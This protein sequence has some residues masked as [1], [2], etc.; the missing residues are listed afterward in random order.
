MLTLLEP[1]KA[2]EPLCILVAIS[3]YPPLLLEEPIH[4]RSSIQ[5][6]LHFQ[7]IHKAYH[8]HIEGHQFGIGL[9]HL[10]DGLPVL[11][12]EG[13]IAELHTGS[14]HRSFTH[15]LCRLGILCERGAGIGKVANLLHKFIGH[16]SAV[17][18]LA[19]SST[20]LSPQVPNKF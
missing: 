15:P 8:V 17:V 3:E 18:L 6:V 7:T 9:Q 2:M 20:E 13:G 5:D 14:T 10:H 19:L 4:D 12:T 16:L 1:L 11:R